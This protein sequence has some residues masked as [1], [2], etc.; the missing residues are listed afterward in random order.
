[1]RY[2]AMNFINAEVITEDF[3]Q[4]DLVAQAQ[5]LGVSPGKLRLSLLA[6]L[7]DPE[8]VLEELL[9]MPIRDL[10][11]IVR[12]HHQEVISEMTE[13]QLALRQ[14]QRE[15]LVEQFRQ[16]F[17][18]HVSANPNLTDEE[19]EEK[20][21]EIRGQKSTETRATWEERVEEWKQRMEDRNENTNNQSPGN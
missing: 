1:M 7:I 2:M 13:E 11:A 6:Q 10:M 14:E 5:E 20:V 17:T 18:D 4:E 16:R 15:D 9:E 3:T 21:N 19:I 12:E 8:L